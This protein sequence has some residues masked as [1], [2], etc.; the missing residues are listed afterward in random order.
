M[1]CS[2]DL[3]FEESVV[4]FGVYTGEPGNGGTNSPLMWSSPVTETPKNGTVEIWE[5]INLTE[6]AHPVHIHQIQ[7]QLLDRTPVA[8][9]NNT[10]L[11]DDWELGFKDTFIAYPDE[12]TRLVLKFDIPGRYVWH[13]HLLEHEDSELM[14]PIVVSA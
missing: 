4:Y 9:P 7:F 8:D 11:P 13:C 12:V 1:N 10:R 5:F 3:S 14:R 2:S 6:D